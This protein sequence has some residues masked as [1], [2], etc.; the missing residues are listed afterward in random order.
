[1]YDAAR[2]CRVPYFAFGLMEV[3]KARQV[4]LS[5]FEV[6]VSLNVKVNDLSEPL[7]VECA[8][9]NKQFAGRG[10]DR[11]EAARNALKITGEEGSRELIDIIR[12][13]CL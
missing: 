4:G 8:S 5:A 9:M 11:L 7:P 3:L 1:M 12:N 10:A 13:N 2:Q 6:V